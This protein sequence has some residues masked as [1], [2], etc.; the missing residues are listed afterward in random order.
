MTPLGIS[1]GE[2]VLPYR[3]GAG[4]RE[5]AL[6]IEQLDEGHPDVLTSQRNLATTLGSCGRAVEA[7]VFDRRGLALSAG[8]MGCRPLCI[9]AW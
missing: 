8:S 9:L 2:E 5:V 4:N 3:M 1:G 6:K 7:V